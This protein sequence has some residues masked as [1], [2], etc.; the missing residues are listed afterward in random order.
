MNPFGADTPG[1]SPA[2]AAAEL[3]ADPI[4]STLPNTN[5][6]KLARYK[7]LLAG[8]EASFMSKYGGAT[9][10][11]TAALYAGGA[12]DGEEDVPPTVGE[13]AA[14][15]MSAPSGMD[16]L[17][18]APGGTYAPD[19]RTFMASS[20]LGNLGLSPQAYYDQQLLRQYRS[21]FPDTTM[22]TLG[23]G[24]P[25]VSD[26]GY[27]PYENPRAPVY[28]QQLMR[29]AGGEISGPG[30]GTS[31]S[32]PAMLSDGEFVMTAR[33]VRGAGNGDRRAGAQRMYDMMNQF[34][35]M[36]R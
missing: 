28:E 19:P 2:E 24:T 32:I 16:L 22:T 12:F 4:Y 33:A 18:G 7:E 34:E 35:S 30:T 27:N 15:L 5:L 20:A 1:M 14:R 17:A 36:S 21:F 26:T 3:A 9:A 25:L 29:A 8:K 11:G 6:E 31:D 10:A 23:E 13:E